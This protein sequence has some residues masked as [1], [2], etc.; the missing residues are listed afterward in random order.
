[1]KA[2]RVAI[3]ARISSDPD[4][5][6]AGVDRQVADCRT[7][8]D[9][10]GWGIAEVFVDNDQSAYNSKTRPAYKKMLE[11][12]KAAELDGVV[13]WHLDRLHRSPKE[14][15][16]FF[17]ACDA[18]GITEL[19]TVFGDVDLA[20]SDGRLV[21]RIMGAVARQESDAKSR[22]LR[23]KHLEL[24][25]AGKLGGRG[26]RRYG[27]EADLVTLRVCEPNI[28]RDCAERVIAG[29][30]IRSLC[31]ELNERGE[32]T[33]SGNAKWAVNTLR[34]ILVS[35]RIA[36]L[37]EHQGATY[38]ATWPAIVDIET[39]TLLRAPFCDP[40]LRRPQ[41]PARTYFL[42]GVV[43]SGRCGSR[44]T[45]RRNTGARSYV[46]INEPGRAGC[47]RLGVR[48]DPLEELVAT[49]A[50]DRLA[51][52]KARRALSRT[53]ET[54]Q[55][56]KL[57]AQLME[58]EDQIDQL[59]R[60]YAVERLWPKAEFARPRDELQ[61]RAETIRSKLARVSGARVVVELPTDRRALDK[62]WAAADAEKRRSTVASVIDRVVVAPAKLGANRFDPGRVEIVWR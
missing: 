29:E 2:A 8:C 40:A 9:A 43:A 58:L 20:T 21:A 49:Q 27:Y 35:A 44:L 45:S 36:G 31:K 38:P 19:G 57:A 60:E 13:V 4:A 30:S 16:E 55:A 51:E 22:R 62:V 15:E 26:V 39:H 34:R 52:P 10:R 25:K 18:A 50:L 32:Q 28:I 42:T 56:R 33:A 17:E 11:G 5:T 7:Y 59:G 24:A 47:G 12:I 6:R 48:A 14:L 53:G 3:Y 23:A 46:C 41:H 37:R 54:N 61:T 1:M